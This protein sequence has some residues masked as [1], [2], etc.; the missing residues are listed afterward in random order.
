MLILCS[1]SV[2]SLFPPPLFWPGDAYISF[3]LSISQWSISTH[4]NTQKILLAAVSPLVCLSVC[5]H[6]ACFCQILKVKSVNSVPLASPSRTVKVII[7][8]LLIRHWSHKLTISRHWLNQYYVQPKQTVQFSMV[9]KQ[10][11]TTM[12]EEYQYC[13]TGTIILFSIIYQM[14]M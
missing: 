3:A 11:I 2:L 10:I 1:D 5:F 8:T 9:L 4:K 6:T 14:Q 12:F 13:Y 7:N